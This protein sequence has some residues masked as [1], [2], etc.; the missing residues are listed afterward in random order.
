MHRT[1]AALLVLGLSGCATANDDDAASRDAATDL[2]VADVSDATATDAKDAGDGGLVD[3][4]TAVDTGSAVD[5]GTLDTGT[6]DTGTLDTGTLDTGTLDTGTPDTGTVDTGTPD[7]SGCTVSP[8]TGCASGVVVI[9]H[10]GG[11]ARTIDIAAG[12]TSFKLALLSYDPTSWTLTG[13]TTRVSS[14]QIFT[15]DAG[16][17]I[18]G[19]TGISTTIQTG[20]T[21]TCSPYTYAGSM[22]ECPAHTGWAGCKFSVAGTSACHMEVG[23]TGACSYPTYSCLRIAP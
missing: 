2:G 8:V 5:T 22:G 1:L 11:G 7:T 10:Y 18:A 16:T 4:G 14:L 13:A 15:Y 3:T 17:T 19:N 12:S 6:L 9:G 23:L 21:G 20:P